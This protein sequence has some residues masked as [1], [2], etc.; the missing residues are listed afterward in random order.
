MLPIFLPQRK[1][2]AYHQ[3]SFTATDPTDAGSN[4]DLLPAAELYDSTERTYPEGLGILASPAQTTALP[5]SPK[6]KKDSRSSTVQR[7]RSFRSYFHRMGRRKHPETPQDDLHT[8][9]GSLPGSNLYGRDLPANELSTVLQQGSRAVERRQHTSNRSF[10]SPLQESGPS[11]IHTNNN[12]PTPRKSYFNRSQEAAVAAPFTFPLQ[13]TPFT[14]VQHDL[15]STPPS[16]T[17]SSSTLASDHASPITTIAP[18]SKL[19]YLTDVSLQSDRFASRSATITETL[20]PAPPVIL[21]GSRRQLLSP[22]RS[23]KENAI[24]IWQRSGRLSLWSAIPSYSKDAPVRQSVGAERGLVIENPESQYEPD[25]LRSQ[26]ASMDCVS[27]GDGWGH[28][29]CQDTSLS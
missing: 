28:D 1:H 22:P 10:S 2:G 9:Q 12:Q 4:L 20:T 25:A 21:S 6:P 15:C 16:L 18:A 27:S 26:R 8:Q 17:S 19:P 13:Q 3:K 5:R 11:W 7:S 24:P 29:P 23:L 14:N